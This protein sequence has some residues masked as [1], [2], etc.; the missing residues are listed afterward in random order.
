VLFPTG[1]L[2]MRVASFWVFA[3]PVLMALAGLIY[4]LM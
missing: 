3:P 4:A 2:V 1:G